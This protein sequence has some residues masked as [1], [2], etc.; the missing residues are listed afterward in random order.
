MKI[1]KILH[2]QNIFA[3][4]IAWKFSV[5]FFLFSTPELQ[6]KIQILIQ[7]HC[8]VISI[9]FVLHKLKIEHTRIGEGKNTFPP[10]IFLSWAL[11]T[12]QMNL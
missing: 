12:S 10:F 4:R 8:S 3:S 7:F 1:L 11:M 9:R 5:V 6:K 2:F